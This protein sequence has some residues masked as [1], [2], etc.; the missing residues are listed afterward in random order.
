LEKIHHTIEFN[1]TPEEFYNAILDP[2]KHSA[3]TQ[4]K[5]DISNVE[6]SSYTAYDGYIE[7]TNLELIPGR[8]IIQSWKASEDNW[9][10]GYYSKI[11]FRISPENRGCKV[12]FTHENIPDGM[13]KMYDEGWK[14][15]YWDKMKLFFKK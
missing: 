2:V 5:V 4:T 3:F 10:E 7:G 11:T 12:E 8:L 13:G 15:N 9:P 6:G 14:E 1:V